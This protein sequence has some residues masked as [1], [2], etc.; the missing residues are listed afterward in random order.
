MEDNF[1]HIICTFHP[2]AVI[3][4]VRT[5][6]N[7]FSFSSPDVG[8]WNI[9]VTVVSRW[10]TTAICSAGHARFITVRS[11]AGWF[12]RAPSIMVP[13]DASSTVSTLRSPSDS[14]QTKTMTLVRN[15]SVMICWQRASVSTVAYF[16]LEPLHHYGTC[17]YMRLILSYAVSRSNFAHIFLL[18]KIS[19]LT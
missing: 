8:K 7:S 15:T 6:F 16:L 13:V 4:Q 1:S 3:W 5:V 11:A 18:W 10:E 14:R 2:F 12:G 9:V 19:K 17:Y